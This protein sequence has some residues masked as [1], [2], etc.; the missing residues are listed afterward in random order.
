MKSKPD[1][2]SNN[3]ERIQNNIDRTI[4]NIEAAEELIS[5]TSDNNLRHELTEKNERREQALDGMRSEIKDEA[6]HE[7][8]QQKKQK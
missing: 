7:Q 6:K 5:E 2:R 3:V 4:Q 8:H 1:D